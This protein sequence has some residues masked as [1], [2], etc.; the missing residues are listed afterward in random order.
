MEPT[1]M[2]LTAY[3]DQRGELCFTAGTVEG[4]VWLEATFPGGTWT[5]DDDARP[6]YMT[7]VRQGGRVEVVAYG[8]AAKRP[9]N[10]P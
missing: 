8:D 3:T 4:V 1:D 2:E 10:R 6:Y 9:E 7:G 5:E